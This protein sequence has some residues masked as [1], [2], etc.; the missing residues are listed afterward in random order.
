MPFDGK[1]L[2]NITKTRNVENTKNTKLSEIFSYADGGNYLNPKHE[3]R[4]PKQYRMIQIRMIQT[5]PWR[6]QMKHYVWNIW[7]FDIWICFGFRYSDLE[8]ITRCFPSP[9]SSGDYERLVPFKTSIMLNTLPFTPFWTYWCRNTTA[10]RVPLAYIS[11]PFTL[12]VNW[13]LTVWSSD[14]SV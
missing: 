9:P 5:R 13:N 12:C 2:K 3:I 8:F 4:N 11:R 7:A 10:S 6:Y 14:V 1:N